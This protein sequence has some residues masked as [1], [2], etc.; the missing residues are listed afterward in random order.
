MGAALPCFGFG[1]ISKASKHA[2]PAGPPI[3]PYGKEAET[4]DADI[5]PPDL[6]HD[7]GS[8]GR[9]SSIH[10]VS[11]NYFLRAEMEKAV[12][13]AMYPTNGFARWWPIVLESARLAIMCFVLTMISEVIAGVDDM[14]TDLSTYHWFFSTLAGNA[15]FYD[16]DSCWPT[17][18]DVIVSDAVMIAVATIVIL[19]AIAKLDQ[20]TMMSLVSQDA[21][22]LVESSKD[23]KCVQILTD[24]GNVLWEHMPSWRR[25]FGPTYDPASALWIGAL[26][27]REIEEFKQASSGRKG[28]R[29]TEVYRTFPMWYPVFFT[30]C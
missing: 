16:P 7:V 3:V 23:L 19:V 20:F 8:S 30:G 27:L 15:K 10:V 2:Q 24:K 28:Q 4:P 25:L 22:S 29:I 13:L 14:V 18:F 11:G 6:E 5:P 12:A 17:A 1:G 21:V 26:R 9:H